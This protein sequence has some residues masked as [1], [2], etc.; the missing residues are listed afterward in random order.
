MRP[1]LKPGSPILPRDR[2]DP[3]IDHRCDRRPAVHHEAA[4]REHQVPFPWAEDSLFALKIAIPRHDRPR[5]AT[6]GP[7]RILD[8][9]RSGD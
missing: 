8:L 3:S 2:D 6:E 7:G 9:P 5:E 4:G 1:P